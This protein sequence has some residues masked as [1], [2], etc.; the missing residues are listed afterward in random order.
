MVAV[1]STVVEAFTAVGS[2]AVDF[3]AADLAVGALASARVWLR[4]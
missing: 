1:D 3:T 4:A 2:M